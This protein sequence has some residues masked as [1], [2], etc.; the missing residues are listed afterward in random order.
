[1]SCLPINPYILRFGLSKGE[2]GIITTLAATTPVMMLPLIWL[3]TGERP[4]L[5]SWLGAILTV[6]GSGILFNF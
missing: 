2:A 5:G 3:K 1:M 6:V 4:A